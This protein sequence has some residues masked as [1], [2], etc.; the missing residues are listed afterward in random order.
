MPVADAQHLLAV[1]V[2]AAGFAPELGRLDRRH[3]HLDRARPVLL[4]A[5]DGADL[6]Q[7]AQA[8]RQPGVDAG[9]LL[10]DHAG[11]Q[12]QPMRDD[13][14]LFRRFLEDRQ[15]IA[16]EAH[17]A[18]SGGRIEANASARGGGLMALR[19]GKGQAQGRFREGR[20]SPRAAAGSRCRPA[21]RAASRPCRGRR[22]SGS[23]CRGCRSDRRSP[24]PRRH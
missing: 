17:R 16:G 13:L 20:F 23:G 5:H 14:R 21:R 2:V 11:A 3:Q 12:H 9:R 1:V 8:Q 19:P 15:E 24:A 22:R 6:L 7:D 4:L 18:C 10:P